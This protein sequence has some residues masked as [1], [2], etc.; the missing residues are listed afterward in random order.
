MSVE[1]VFF[2][3]FNNAQC[4]LHSQ[5]FPIDQTA[6]FILIAIY[7][8]F[9]NSH[10][11]QFFL[12]QEIIAFTVMLLFFEYKIEP[13]R[14]PNL[15]LRRNNGTFTV[16]RCTVGIRCFTVSVYFLLQINFF[17]STF[18]LFFWLS[19]PFAILWKFWYQFLVLPYVTVNLNSFRKMFAFS[20]M[21]LI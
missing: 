14:F 19:W 16:L 11:W 2:R 13:C 8:L 18:D 20:D 7:N 15:W 10:F 17:K 3:F 5:Y 9:F 4:S 21:D 1:T 6:I 12:K